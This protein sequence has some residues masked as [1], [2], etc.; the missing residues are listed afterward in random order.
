MSTYAYRF[1][2]QESLPSRLPDFDLEQFFQLLKSTVS[3]SQVH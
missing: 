3:A 1:V 2:G